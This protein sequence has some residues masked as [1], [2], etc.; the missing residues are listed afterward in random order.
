MPSV[1]LGTVLPAASL[2][3]TVNF[4]LLTAQAN[5]LGAILVLFHS[6]LTKVHQ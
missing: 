6:D 1:V 2:S 4:V 3:I 5:T